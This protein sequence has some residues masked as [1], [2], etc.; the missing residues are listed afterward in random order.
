MGAW[1]CGFLLPTGGE[2]ARG[3]QRLE[4]APDRCM[5]SVWKSFVTRPASAAPSRSGPPSQVGV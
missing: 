3:P 4:T 5:G 2:V 1:G